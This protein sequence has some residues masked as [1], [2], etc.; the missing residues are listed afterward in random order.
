[1]SLHPE[2]AHAT[3]HQ[4]VRQPPVPQTLAAIR[5]LLAHHRAARLEA[6]WR[7]SGA[8]C[9]LPCSRRGTIWSGASWG[10]ASRCS[11]SISS[12]AAAFA[13]ANKYIKVRLLAVHLL[14]H[15]SDL[16]HNIGTQTLISCYCQRVPP[17]RMTDRSLHQSQP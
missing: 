6:R 9:S 16:H 5:R 7:V 2:A 1:M 12:S 10:D 11:V 13:A 4:R 14:D 15:L 8:F 17:D 3:R